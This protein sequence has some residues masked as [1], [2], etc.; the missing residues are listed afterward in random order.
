M[1]T[2][3]WVE[4][5]GEGSVELVVNDVLGQI[6]TLDAN[7]I[8]R[9]KNRIPAYLRPYGVLVKPDFVSA[10][11]FICSPAFRQ[12]DYVLLD[13]NLPVDCADL[14]RNHPVFK[15]LELYGYCPGSTSPEESETKA[16]EALGNVAGYRLYIELLES[17]F[18]KTHVLFCSDHGDNMNGVYNAFSEAKL[19]LPVLYAKQKDEDLK[20]IHEWLGDACDNR[21]SILRRGIFEGCAAALQLLEDTANIRFHGFI[22]NAVAKELKSDL[23]IYLETLQAFL[24]VREPGEKEKTL[25]FK[26]FT[27]TLLHEW[28][29][30]AQPDNFSGDNKQLYQ[31]LAWIMK[32]ARNWIAHTKLLNDLEEADVAFLFIT[33]LR[34]M[35]KFDE[36]G[37]VTHEKIL[38]GL[39]E[40]VESETLRAHIQQ[41]ALPLAETYLQARTT[42]LNAATGNDEILFRKILDTMQAKGCEFDY[43]L[44]LYQSFWHGL[45]PVSMFGTPKKPEKGPKNQIFCELN[46]AFGEQNFGAVEENFVFEFACRLYHRSFSFPQGGDCDEI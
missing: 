12:T 36:Q 22:K 44:G 8:P 42:L 16:A 46:C 15:I 40:A 24:P 28:E 35:F 33:A 26:L 34:A 45:A 41:Q 25:L 21:Y 18:P 4:D 17:G 6:F 30:A 32:N 13:I 29:N 9:T 3:L 27:R 39:F 37:A 14:E 10:F 1:S 11:E 43:L 38:F 5:F 19:E 31:T 23:Q 2:L 7:S 20:K